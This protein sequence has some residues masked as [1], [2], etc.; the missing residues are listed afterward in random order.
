MSTLLVRDRLTR[1]LFM[2]LPTG[3]YLVSNV[4]YAPYQPIFAE[5]VERMEAR[6]SQWARIRSSYVD[7]RTCDVYVDEA[8]YHAW[9]ASHPISNV[10]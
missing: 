4:G 5:T 3:S 1:W 6:P 10:P 9:V 7:Q 2:Q 8:A